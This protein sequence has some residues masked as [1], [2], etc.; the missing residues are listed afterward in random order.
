MTNNLLIEIKS[1]K[2]LHG[3]IQL[4]ENLDFSWKKGQHW[5]IIG[6]S[7]KE[8]TA[9]LETLQGHTVVRSGEITRPFAKEYS[10]QKNADGEVH[11]FRD[12]IAYVSQRYELKNRSNQQ[13]FYFQQRFNSSESEQTETVREYL[14]KGHSSLSGS[15][16]IEKVSQALNLGHLLDRSL[17]KL[18][19][20]ETRR[21][22]LALGLMRQPLIYLMDQPL[23][24][25]DAKTRQE[26]GAILHEIIQAGIHVMMTTSPDEIPTGV[27]HVAQINASGIAQTWTRASFPHREMA[28]LKL[29]WDWRLFE[30]LI[31]ATAPSDETLIQLENVSIKYG[32]KQILKDLSWKIRSGERWLL[33]GANGSGKSTLISLLIGE[34]PQAYSQ[35]IFLFGRKRGSGESIWDVKRPIGFMAPELPRFF[36][37]NQTCH[38]VILSGF[39]DTMGLFKKTTPDQ[40]SSSAAWLKVF[41]LAAVKDI[42]IQRLTLAQQRWTLLARALIK[43]PKILVLDEASQGLDDLQRAL[44]K[45]T[46]QKICELSSITLIYV[47][48]YAEDIPDAVTQLKEL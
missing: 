32:E 25:L 43:Q 37:A 24:G 45:E 42:P 6:N 33:R 27:T 38:K 30:K 18:S 13:N 48:H 2:I 12:L 28:Q 36:P 3:G 10:Q 41:E 7:G 39:F 31:P 5:A 16:T 19:N 29:E 40:E 14:Q 35:Q 1:A 8:L 20:G 21:L 15:W 23:T 44:F 34:N 17:L 22:V 11:S 26:F 9:F 4:F 47:S 46:V